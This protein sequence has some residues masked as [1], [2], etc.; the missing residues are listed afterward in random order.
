[1]SGLNH[2]V[3]PYLHAEG[4]RKDLV[5]D[6]GRTFT[7]VMA[8]AYD[9]GGLIGPE[10][11]GLVV[12][13]ADNANVVL[14]GHMREGSG[15]HG[16]S[17]RQKAEFVRVAGITDWKSFTAYLRSNPS[18]RRNT[19]P[20]LDRPVPDKPDEAAI[21]FKAAREGKLPGLPG[22]SILPAELVAAHDDPEVRYA[23]P[24][25][26]RLDIVA[27]LASHAVHGDYHGPS[28][29]AWNI[30]VYDVDTSGRSEGF[31]PDPAFDALWKAYVEKNTDLVFQE[32][33]GDGL[34]TYLSGEASAYPGDSQGDFEFSVGGRSGGW[35]ELVK[36]KGR[37]LGFRSMSEMIKT[38]LEMDE[39]DLVGLYAGVACFDA[40]IEP[41]KDMDFQIS[42]YRQGKEEDWSNP[43]LAEEAAAELGLE[44]WT[45]PRTGAPRA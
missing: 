17:L 45:H 11:N 12:I 39:A 14:D 19:V 26:T 4:M 28:H 34:R 15:Y 5:F 2:R 32:A 18:Y 29:L 44:D 8:G 42:N 7:V 6:G 1:M 37:P 38:L 13:D 10:H 22:P 25:R 3:G 20:D 24:L 27:H 16:P 23:F 35:L 30:K 41:K 9:A 33:A 31:E 40:D 43:E 36:F 21:V